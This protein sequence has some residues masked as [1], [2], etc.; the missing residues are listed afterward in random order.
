MLGAVQT[1]NGIAGAGCGGGV[2]A[3]TAGPALTR[4]GATLATMAEDPLEALERRV[5]LER[6]RPELARASLQDAVGL[7]GCR[8][9]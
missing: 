2:G 5:A 1:L 6:G 7:A 9:G 4:A 3:D 8:Q